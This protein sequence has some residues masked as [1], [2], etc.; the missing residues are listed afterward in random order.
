MKIKFIL[1]AFSSSIFLILIASRRKNLFN[2]RAFLSESKWFLG[3]VAILVII[4][5]F[6]QV[7]NGFRSFVIAEFLYLLLPILF[8]ILVV[9]T[10]SYSITRVLDNC[11]YILII[12]FILCNIDTLTPSAIASI[13]FSESFSPFESSSS[14]IFVCFELYFLIRYGKRNGKSL[15]CLLLTVLTLKRFCVIKAVLF[16]I[17]VPMIKNKK[18]PRWIFVLVIIFF[19]ALPFLLEYIYSY[20]FALLMLTKYG[21]DLNDLTMDRYR[22]ISYVISHMD[23]IKYGFGS[24]TYFLTNN[25]SGVR[26]VNRSLHSDILRIYLE[27]SFIGSFGFTICNFAAVRKNVVSFLLMFHVFTEMIVNHPLGAGNVGNW[28]IIYL[29]IVYFNY[30]KVIP[31]YKEGQLKRKRI[32]IGRIMI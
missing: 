21:T 31:F 19:C 16:F 12:A 3:A 14:I 30:R 24:A 13:K 15:V 9:S 17:F 25:L 32:K 2:N 1:L 5:I 10:D 8:V 7:M 4:T 6:Y 11:F 18:L 28:I 22:R 27:C 26:L 20:D 29:M 23:Q